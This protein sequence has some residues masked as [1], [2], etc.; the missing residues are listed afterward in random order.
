MNERIH[1]KK[2]I[3]LKPFKSKKLPIILEERFLKMNNET[4]KNKLTISHI[5]YSHS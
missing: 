2:I 1:I 3:T 5:L 4:E